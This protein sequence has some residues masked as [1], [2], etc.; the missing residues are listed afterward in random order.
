MP[1]LIDCHAHLLSE[2]IYPSALFSGRFEVPEWLVM[3]LCEAIRTGQEIPLVQKLAWKVFPDKL[4]KITRFLRLYVRDIVTQAEDFKKIAK[5]AGIDE[6]WILGIDAPKIGEYG[7]VATDGN[8]LRQLNELETVSLLNDGFFKLFYPF[9]PRRVGSVDFMKKKLEGVFTGVKMYSALGFNVEGACQEQWAWH[10][11][12]ET[13]FS[14]LQEKQIPIIVHCSGGGIKG[15]EV[16][17]G[18][19]KWLSSPER[20]SPVLRKYP[21]LKVCFAHATGQGGFLS[22]AREERGPWAQT[23]ERLMLTYPG[24]YADI[25]FHEGLVTDT[26]NYVKA[27]EQILNGPLGKRILFGSDYP[28]QLTAY[29]YESLIQKA[30]ESLP[31]FETQLCVNAEAFMGH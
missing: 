12:L 31:G 15:P 9:D 18:D 25:S 29:S 17:P 5:A 2:Y 19:M 23:L 13:G 24:V 4:K 28:L 21:N 10:D 7:P 14:Y 20:W 27:F 6:A 8:L 16:K 26:K 3:G 22:L 30:R 11:A 1:K